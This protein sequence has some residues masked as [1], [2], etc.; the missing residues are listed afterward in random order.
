MKKRFI[1]P[2]RWLPFRPVFGFLGPPWFRFY[3][4]LAEVPSSRAFLDKD[5]PGLGAAVAGGHP[6]GE[7]NKALGEGH[8]RATALCW[9]AKSLVGSRWPG[10]PARA[11]PR[12]KKKKRG[13]I[14]RAGARDVGGKSLSASVSPS[15]KQRPAG[16]TGGGTAATGPDAVGN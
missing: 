6:G 1:R 7:G 13:A 4:P 14:F 3:H 10:P 12:K 5:L 16:G 8:R 11:I 15:H 9:R 2:H